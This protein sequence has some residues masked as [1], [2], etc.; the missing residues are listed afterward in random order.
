MVLDPRRIKALFN[1]A[2]DVPIPTDRPAFLDRE[3]GDD[4]DLRQ[5]VEELLVAYDR[6]A[7]ALVQ[8][9]AADTGNVT[10][11]FSAPDQPAAARR[12]RRR[13]ALRARRRI[14]SPKP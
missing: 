10:S 6:P 4:R 14:W 13:S 12:V 7:S 9:L 1:A 3:C 8:P 2:L 11:P 5:R